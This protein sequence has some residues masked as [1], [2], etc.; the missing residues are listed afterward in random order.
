ME[1]AVEVHVP[2]EDEESTC[3]A[4]GHKPHQEPLDANFVVP[5]FF[6]ESHEFDID[7]P[8]HVIP[9]YPVIN[10]EDDNTRQ[11]LTVTR[12]FYFCRRC[13]CWTYVDVEEGEVPT[14]PDWD[15]WDSWMILSEH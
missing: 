3:F 11:V 9:H 10:T 2:F 4:E 7:K 12:K 13:V 14:N 1:A 6:R 8:D 15:E 5:F